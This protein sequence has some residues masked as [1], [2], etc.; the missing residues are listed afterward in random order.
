MRRK[1]LIGLMAAVWLCVLVGAQ[2]PPAGQKPAAPAAQ[3]PQT[4]YE[5]ADALAQRLG[6]QLN[7]R[8]VVGEP[9]K[10]GA[11]TLVP[12]MMI[13]VNFGG[14]GGGMPQ[15]PAMGGSGFFMKGEGRLL[16]FVAVG[17]KGT[18]FIGLGKAAGAELPAKATAGT[19]VK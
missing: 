2:N 15:N 1:I 14:G 9:S 18:R 11:V 5:L 10:A 16:G 17:K 13:D 6:K 8:T 3:A 19:P 12:I 7:V 4:P